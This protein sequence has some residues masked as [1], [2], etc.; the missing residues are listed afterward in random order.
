MRAIVAAAIASGDVTG[1]ELMERAGR[2][3]VSA[4]FA[5]WPELAPSWGP[6]PKPPE[7]FLQDDE[8][9]KHRAVVLCGPGNNGGDGFVVA[10][11]LFEAGWEVEVFL[12]GDAEKL[13]L[14]AKVNYARW[15]EVGE[16]A[17]L[18]NEQTPEF[19]GKNIVIDALF[20]TG[21]PHPLKD[22]RYLLRERSDC[23][24]AGGGQPV[25]ERAKYWPPVV[26]I[27]IPSGICSDSGR[28][29]FLDFA[30]LRSG[31]A[32]ACAVADLTVTFHSKKLGHKQSIGAFYC[33]RLKCVD[34]GVPVKAARV[35]GYADKVHE[36]SSA[37]GV[38]RR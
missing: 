6:T 22:F 17:T 14:D 13:P 27:D 35:F 31:A 21:L 34:I 3:V 12:Y 38:Y 30:E 18:S 1:L 20:G 28:V 10:R 2:G 33:G 5:E 24:D 37:S 9:G 36:C 19:S 11:L 15:C 32:S 25:L 16:L 8:K 29:L 7:Y 4:I 23:V 26:A